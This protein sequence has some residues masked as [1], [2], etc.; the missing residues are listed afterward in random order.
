MGSVYRYH[1][2]NQL[3]GDYYL[4]VTNHHSI[5]LLDDYKVERVTLS[6]ELDDYKIRDIMKY[7]DNVEM[8]VYGRLELMVMKYCPLKK[9][10]NYCNSCK[11]GKDN[12][13]L[14]DKFNNRY[15]MIRKNCLT[16]IMHHKVIDKIDNISSYKE[17]GVKYYR[18]ELFDENS[19]KINEIIFIFIFVWRFSDNTKIACFI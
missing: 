4:N 8:I 16:H 6:V 19:E 14:E 11:S 9:C 2:N 17:M 3:I 10:L 5:T 12:F 1:K 13:Y 15:P 7:Q 18:L